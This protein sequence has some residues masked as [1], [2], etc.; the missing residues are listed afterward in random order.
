MTHEEEIAHLREENQALREALSQVLTR[1][2]ELEKQK[3]P[4]LRL[5]K[6]T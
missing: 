1:I 6:Q 5:S 3:T 2:E 4:P